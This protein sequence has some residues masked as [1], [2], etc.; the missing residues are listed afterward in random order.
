MLVKLNS[1]IDNIL[2]ENNYYIS[3]NVIYLHKIIIFYV[4]FNI[5]TYEKD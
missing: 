5:C 4:N 2:P 1:I 3:F